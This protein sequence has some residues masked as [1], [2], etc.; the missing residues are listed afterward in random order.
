MGCVNV[1]VI[2]LFSWGFACFETGR[3]LCGDVRV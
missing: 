1:S 3:G 2:G